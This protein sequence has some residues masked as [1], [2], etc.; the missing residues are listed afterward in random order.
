MI[1]QLYTLGEDCQCCN[2]LQKWLDERG[3]RYN[4]VDLTKY[5]GG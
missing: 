2:K 3:I 4:V 5:Q 1:L